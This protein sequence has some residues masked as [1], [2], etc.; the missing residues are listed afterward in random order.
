MKASQYERLHVICDPGYT[1]ILMAEVGEAGYD[2]FMETEEGFEAYSE[3][4]NYDRNIL[5]CVQEK[6]RHVKPLLFRHDKVEKKTGT[7]SGKRT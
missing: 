7:K 2:T 1:E 4:G 5:N 6:Y 3:E